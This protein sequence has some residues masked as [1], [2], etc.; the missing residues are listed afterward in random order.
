MILAEAGDP[1]HSV[2]RIWAAK[3]G[4]GGRLRYWKARLTAARIG[5]LLEQEFA[6]AIE[7]YNQAIDLDPT[8]AILYGNRSF[9]HLKLE[10]FGYALEDANKATQLDAK[11]VKGYYRRA[12][13]YMSLGKF[14][15]ALKDFEAV[16]KAC[17]SD[18]DAKRRFHECRKVWQR[19]AFENAIRV[20]DTR[21]SV[22]DSIDVNS[23]T[24]DDDYDGPSLGDDGQVTVEFMEALLDTL[25]KQKRLHRKYAYKMLLS[26]KKYFEQQ[27]T[28]V[29]IEVPA[30][31]KFTIC[32]DIH[33]QF[34]DL[35]NIFKL[36]GP[37]S[38]T[39][40]Y[41]FNGDFVDRGSFSVECILTLFGYKLLYPNHFYMS[42][43]NHESHTMNQMYGFEGEVR[44]KYTD[45]MAQLFTEVF[46]CIPLAHVINGKVFVTHGGLFSNDGI[47]LRDIRETDRFR[48]PPETGVMCDLLWSD[49]ASHQGREPSKRGVGIQF[50]P[51]VT[52]RFLSEN[53]LEYVVRSHEVKPEGYEVAHGGKCITVFSAPNYCDQMGNKGAFIT[54]RGDDLT[55]NYTVYDAVVS[56]NSAQC[57][58]NCMVS[59]HRVSRAFL[60][61]FIGSPLRMNTAPLF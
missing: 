10:N 32:G 2:A 6:N 22:A 50:G 19:L 3:R 25:E 37:P 17:P 40:P 42:R 18:Q 45:Q 46:C 29:D 28:L 15:L 30:G 9:A 16:S 33:G 39:N 8:K 26:I 13:A 35:L 44:S 57:C 36:N 11:Y 52:E 54:I 23:I 48:E 51:D 21:K 55:P 38:E 31:S 27:P 59:F 7:L 24:I 34:Y 1:V 5:W 12:Q 53:G 56:C 20:E 41:L 58:I 43:G 47:T 4:D 60:P 49:P 61:S 14:K